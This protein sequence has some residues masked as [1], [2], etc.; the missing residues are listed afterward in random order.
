[1]CAVDHDELARV[2]VIGKQLATH[3]VEAV[4]KFVRLK[5]VEVP[6][7]KCS[8][9]EIPWLDLIQCLAERGIAPWPAFEGVE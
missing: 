3:R 8:V 6:P 9:G 5:V 7:D 2:I 4:T 1:M